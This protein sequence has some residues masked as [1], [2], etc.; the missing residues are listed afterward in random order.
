MIKY[1]ASV[2]TAVV[3]SLFLSVNVFASGAGMIEKTAFT[4][5]STNDSAAVRLQFPGMIEYMDGELC[6]RLYLDESTITTRPAQSPTY[7][8]QTTQTREITGLSRNDP[9]LIERTWE[10]MVLQDVSFTRT[11]DRSYTAHAV[12]AGTATG[13]REVS[14]ISAAKYFGEGHIAY[15][16]FTQE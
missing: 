1:T 9:A 4:R 5:T 11:G 3:L 15:E 13:T 2:L 16:F 10:G 7:T 12:Y 6:V 14:Y 8:Y